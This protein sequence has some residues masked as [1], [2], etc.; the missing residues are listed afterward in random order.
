MFFSPVIQIFLD[1]L[2]EKEQE[3]ALYGLPLIYLVITVIAFF[4]IKMIIYKTK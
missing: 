3:L 4:R 2:N 1:S